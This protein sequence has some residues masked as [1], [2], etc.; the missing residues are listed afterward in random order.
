[1]S[2][3][4]YVGVEEIK[5]FNQHKEEML[6]K[7]NVRK[8]MPAVE[9]YI[10]RNP[11]CEQISK[12]MGDSAV[13]DL[14]FSP[15]EKT[16][17]EGGGAKKKGGG[18]KGAKPNRRPSRSGGGAKRSLNENEN[19]S[20]DSESSDQTTGPQ[21]RAKNGRFKRLPEGL[22]KAEADTSG[23]LELKDSEDSM[24]LSGRHFGFLLAGIVGDL[25]LENL[26]NSGHRVSVLCV[27]TK[28]EVRN[29][30]TH[31]SN[32]MHGTR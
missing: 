13:T 28:S 9:E 16:E 18:S 7:T 5:P 21:P 15:R 14:Q 10:R 6:C 25:I 20:D 3:S 24:K 22:K 27:D 19:D 12:S 23:V 31:Y 8:A 32:E 30:H 17:E 1:M 2:V 11:E 29:I 26:I 4:A